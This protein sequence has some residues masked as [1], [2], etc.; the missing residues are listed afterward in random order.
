MF[1]THEEWELL[2]PSPRDLEESAAQE[3]RK[4]QPPEGG[5]GAV[6]AAPVAGPSPR[7]PVG[8][9][10]RGDPSCRCLFGEAR[11]PGRGVHSLWG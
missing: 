6:R 10:G 11:G 4:K 1:Y 7:P 9:Q 2:D 3:E 8:P 5:K